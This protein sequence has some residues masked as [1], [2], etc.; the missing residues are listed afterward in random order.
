MLFIYVLYFIAYWNILV[1]LLCSFN[2]AFSCYMYLSIWNLGVYPLELL[3]KK[4]GLLHEVQISPKMFVLVAKLGLEGSI[5]S[6]FYGIGIICC[7]SSKFGFS[8]YIYS[9]IPSWAWDCGSLLNHLWCSCP[10]DFFSCFREIFG[11]ILD[12]GD[13]DF[14][15]CL[16]YY[17]CYFFINF[18]T[19]WGLTLPLIVMSSW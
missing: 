6:L 4:L 13:M 18:T 2:S 1:V 8:S 17:C 9:S 16:S 5:P 3:S 14:F 12:V 10:F 7:T 19:C 11:F 15:F